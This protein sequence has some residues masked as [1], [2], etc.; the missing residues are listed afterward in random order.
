[1]LKNQSLGLSLLNTHC[2]QHLGHTL[3]WFYFTLCYPYVVSAFAPWRLP[4]YPFE[5]LC[6]CKALGITSI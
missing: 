3:V 1:M 6:R 2:L 5:S 4:A